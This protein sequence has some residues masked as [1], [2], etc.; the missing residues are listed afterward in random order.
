M[1]DQHNPPA[2]A[3]ASEAEELRP[4][5]A[6][7]WRPAGTVVAAA[8]ALLVTWHVISGQHGL[9]SWHKMRAE[10]RELQSEIK[11]LEKENEELRKENQKLESDPE[12]IRHHARE[13]L[14]YAG[15]DEVIYTLP[16][17]EAEQEK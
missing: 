8:L 9:S 1:Q 17:S 7:I 6:R 14:H 12:A 13:Q 16:A 15:Q 11:K 4:W 2:H 10:D 5:T 3:A